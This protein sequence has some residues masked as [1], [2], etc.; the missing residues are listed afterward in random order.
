MR[1]KL[2]LKKSEVEIKSLS[3]GA[4]YGWNKTKNKK[5]DEA[6]IIKVETTKNKS[7]NYPE[8]ELKNDIHSM[9]YTPHQESEF[10]QY[11]PN[12]VEYQESHSQHIGSHM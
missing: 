3:T 11:N 5:K 12:K 2:K 1:S 10:I 4:N 9:Y 8:N 6:S 7:S